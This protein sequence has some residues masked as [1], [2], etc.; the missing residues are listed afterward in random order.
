VPLQNSLITSE[1]KKYMKKKIF[2]TILMALI[3][4]IS[5]C[6]NGSLKSISI[7]IEGSNQGNTFENLYNFG[8][9]ANDDENIYY[10]SLFGGLYKFNLDSN[11][12][13][14]LIN[15]VF[16]QSLNVLDGWIYYTTLF[17]GSIY[18]IS[19]NGTDNQ[20]ISEVKASLLYV[21]DNTLYAHGNSKEFN[22]NIYVIDI[23]G[24]GERVLF[25]TPVSFF[26]V[27][28]DFIYYRER[29]PT[30]RYRR[31][32]RMRLDGSEQSVIFEHFGLSD[33]FIIHNNSLLYSIMGNLYEMN[34]A[35]N[36][37]RKILEMGEHLQHTRNIHQNKFYYTTHDDSFFGSRLTLHSFDLITHE[38]TRTTIPRN[39]QS[40]HPLFFDYIIGD[41]IFRTHGTG[42]LMMDLDGSNIQSFPN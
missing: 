9:I 36:S 18:K 32:V 17:D 21:L 40:P 6:G 25:D 24:N 20:K 38:K 39:R 13:T 2:L 37:E 15:N 1:G 12:T 34:L 8:M 27:H 28:D 35:D 16:A 42:F 19:V 3:I 41:K 7:E 30:D 14:E 31:I 10:A 22:S 29:T 5:S 11:E 4:L 23:K 33:W 26:Y